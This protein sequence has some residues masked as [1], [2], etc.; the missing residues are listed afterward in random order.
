MN[1]R[2]FRIG[3]T[4]FGAL[5]A[6]VILTIVFGKAPSM[7]FGND[8]TVKVRFE[9]APGIIR[10]SPVYKSGVR[11]GEVI[12]V[13]L[14][15]DDRAV[16]VWLRIMTDRKIYTDEVCRIRQTMIMGDASLE[17]VRDSRFQ[18]EVKLIDPEVPIIGEDTVDFLSGFS[19][20]EGDLLKAIN[21][22]S[23]AAAQV[24]N[25]S[26]K[27]GGFVEKTNEAVGSEEELKVRKEQLVSLLNDIQETMNSFRKMSDG[28]NRFVSDPKIQ[29]D[30]RKVIGDLPVIMEQSKTLVSETNLFIK[31]ARTFVERGGQSLDKVESGLDKATAAL[32]SIKKITDSIENDVPEITDTLKKSTAKLGSFFDEVTMLVR[33]VNNSDGSIMK[34]FREPDF[35]DK[36]MNTLTHVE[37][38][39]GDADRMLQTEV[40]PIAANVRILTDK[41]ARDPAIF[42]RNLIRKQPRTKNLPQ[43]GD[44][45]GSDGL[46]FHNEWTVNG[47]AQSVGRVSYREVPESGIE[48][49]EEIPADNTLDLSAD[50]G[51]VINVDP[52]YDAGQ[53]QQAVYASE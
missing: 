30:I 44:G 4:V 2:E 36:L 25:V 34:L 45:W 31:D 42:I 35:Y 47:T 46:C 37:K 53:I 11:I 33:A 24:N 27:I 14:I 50:E 15:E 13:Q 12:R 39:T 43:W 7:N 22:V 10:R 6:L 32:T 41:A 1:N 26:E 52:R 29:A 3:V 28:M 40:K 51:R 49:Y 5:T 23:D 9:R 16:E 21:N 8:Y 17:L 48:Y 20:I 38:I 18:G 19:N